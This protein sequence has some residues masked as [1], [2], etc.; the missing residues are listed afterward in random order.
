MTLVLVF[1]LGITCTAFAGPFADVP[2]KHWAYDAVSKLAAAGIVDG[3]GDGTF[4]GDRTMTR[5]E[6]AQ[7]VGKAMERS[8]KADA[9]NKALI[10]KLSAEFAS[11][12]DSLGIRVAS[13]EKKVGNIT[14]TGQ[15]R[16][17]YQWRD[18]DGPSK[19]GLNTRLLLFMNAP[20]TD[21][22]NFKGRIY[23]ESGWGEA[24]LEGNNTGASASVDQAYLE[25]QHGK[26]GWTLGRQGIMLGK[27]LV[28]AW[29]PN[30]DGVTL[31]YGGDKTKLT[32]AAFRNEAIFLTGGNDVFLNIAAANL[33]HKVS[34]DLDL[35]AVYAKNKESDVGHTVIDTW[36]VGTTYK[37]INNVVL[38]GEYGQNKAD[39][40]ESVNGGDSAKGWVAQAKYKGADFAK[41]HSWGIWAGYRNAE[42]GFAGRNGDYIWETP[43]NLGSLNGYMMDNVKGMDVGIDYTVFKNGVLTLQYFDLESERDIPGDIND[44]KSAV[45]QLRY[46]F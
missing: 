6:M 41:P 36:A 12:L 13:L 19:T 3:Y 39:Y 38:T 37:G 27:G 8:D 11:E 34:D 10:N 46:M 29:F 26:L 22:I 20:L 31:S 5:Y 33:S 23:A 42:L 32:A 9:E 14:W 21:E 24:S 25:G 44:K 40:A 4:R 28:Y 16:E 7:I 30:N 15:V 17:W 35:T 1:V 43:T 2:A 45:A 18:A